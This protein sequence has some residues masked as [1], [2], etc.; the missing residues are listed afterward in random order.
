MLKRF[1][2]DF[3]APVVLLGIGV[4]R[5]AA[6]DLLLSLLSLLMGAIYLIAGIRSRSRR[7]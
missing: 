7:F 2:W 5:L 1:P 3:W 4:Y 6:G